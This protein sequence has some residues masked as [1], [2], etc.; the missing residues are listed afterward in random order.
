MID[1]INNIFIFFFLSIPILLITGPALP[2][3]VISFGAIFTLIYIFLNKKYLELKNDRFVQ[4]SIL[5]WLV[6]L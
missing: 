6:C 4:I 3:I 1:R 2:D 5:F